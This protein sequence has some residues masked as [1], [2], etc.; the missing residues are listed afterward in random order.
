MSYALYSKSLDLKNVVKHYIYMNLK[1]ECTTRKTGDS[2]MW[3]ALH[4]LNIRHF[5]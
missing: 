5:L 1:V 4:S 3:F 2:W